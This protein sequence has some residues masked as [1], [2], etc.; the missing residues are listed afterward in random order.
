M[1]E[2]TNKK[3]KKKRKLCFSTFCALPFFRVSGKSGLPD[4]KFSNLVIFSKALLHTEKANLYI[5]SKAVGLKN[6]VLFMAVWYFYCHIGIF[7]VHLVF[8]VAIFVNFLHSGLLHQE[9]SGSP[10]AKPAKQDQS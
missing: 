6:L 3:G 4:G 1:A 2:Q 8:F 10:G 9:K 5:F 7:C